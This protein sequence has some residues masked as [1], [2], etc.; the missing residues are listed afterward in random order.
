MGTLRGGTGLVGRGVCVT[1]ESG[2]CVGAEVVG[3]GILSP[4]LEEVGVD[5]FLVVGFRVKGFVRFVSI[6]RELLIGMSW[7]VLACI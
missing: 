5:I 3:R 4:S 1:P 2:A 7:Y 6:G